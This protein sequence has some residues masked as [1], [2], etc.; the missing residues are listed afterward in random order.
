MAI[1]TQFKDIQYRKNNAV[2]LKIVLGSKATK[3][4]H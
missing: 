3:T 2:E 1:I 4:A